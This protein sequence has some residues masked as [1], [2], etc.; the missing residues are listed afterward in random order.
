MGVTR[1]GEGPGRPEQ[2]GNRRTPHPRRR[3]QSADTARPAALTVAELLDPALAGLLVATAGETSHGPMIDHV[4][5]SAHLETQR[6]SFIDREEA[7]GQLSDQHGRGERHS[8][9]RRA[10]PRPSVPSG[11][12]VEDFGQGKGVDRKDARRVVAIAT[13]DAAVSMS[14]WRSRLPSVEPSSVAGARQNRRLWIDVTQN[15]ADP[16]ARPPTA[17]TGPPT[18]APPPTWSTC[19]AWDDWP[20]LGWRRHRGGSCGNWCATGPKLVHLCSG[21]KAQVPAVLAKEAKEGSRCP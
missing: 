8:S 2:N 7:N 20:R 15:A 21:L 4:A 9:I 18:S 1:H 3:L 6:L 19:C 16:L 14:S 17:G 10:Q 5:F 13:Q 12:S 11:W